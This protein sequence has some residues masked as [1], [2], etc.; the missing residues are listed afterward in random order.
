M[1]FFDCY[2]SSPTD[3]FVRDQSDPEGRHCQTKE[4]KQKNKNKK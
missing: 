4:A 1:L 2:Q 3:M